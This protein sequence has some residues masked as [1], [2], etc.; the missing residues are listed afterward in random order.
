ME[1]DL[2]PTKMSAHGINCIIPKESARNELQRI[3]YDELVDG[4]VT[5]E[6]QN[7]LSSIL[8]ELLTDGADGVVLACT[9]LP[10][11]LGASDAPVPMLDSTRILARAALN[12]ALR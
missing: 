9:E 6:S 7:N 10:L 2:Y 3:I 1:S 4:I 12:Y 8:D 5:S 11:I